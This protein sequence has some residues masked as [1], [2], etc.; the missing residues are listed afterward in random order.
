MVSAII[1]AAGFSNRMKDKNKLLVSINGKRIIEYVVES[2]LNS[3]FEEVIIVYKDDEI[4]EIAKKYNIKSSYND[5]SQKGQSTSL[6]CGLKEVSDN[7]DGCMLVLGDMPFVNSEIMNA[8]IKSFDNVH[9]RISVPFYNEKRGN[10]VLIGRDYYNELLNIQ[11]DIG[12]R[13]IVSKYSSKLCKVQ[14]N[15]DLANMDVDN[16]DDL[17]N[18]TKCIML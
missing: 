5:N 6:I 16:Y 11:G 18:I 14:V 10:P 13:N 3:N 9:D 1:M 12:A 17:E 15:N 7:S 8:L 4:K 2:C